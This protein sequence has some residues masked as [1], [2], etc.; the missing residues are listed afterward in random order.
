MMHC[1]SSPSRKVLR[2]FL[3][4]DTA[5]LVTPCCGL[6]GNS[7]TL[8]P[9]IFSRLIGYHQPPDAY[10]NQHTGER[11]LAYLVSDRL[12][13]PWSTVRCSKPNELVYQFSGRDL[14][15]E[16]INEFRK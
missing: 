11:I 8:R 16:V 14:L 3:L 4:L 12:R 15:L 5:L 9:T 7:A 6:P 13:D 10:C 1:A 2:N